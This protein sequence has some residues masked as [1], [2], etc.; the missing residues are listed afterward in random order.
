MSKEEKRLRL[1]CDELNIALDARFAEVL[2]LS[3]ALGD[4]VD[5]LPQCVDC[6]AP[7]MRAYSGLKPTCDSHAEALQ[8][9]WDNISPPLPLLYAA[10]L[11]A[12]IS[13]LSTKD[14]P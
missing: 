5:A 9:R 10:P 14:K 12:A 3:T 4:L 6:G 13:L 7:A 1:H 11:R 8:K 2:A